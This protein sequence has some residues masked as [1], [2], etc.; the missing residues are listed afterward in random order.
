M[1]VQNQ[2]TAKWSP[3]LFCFSGRRGIHM[4]CHPSTGLHVLPATGRKTILEKLSRNWAKW[5]PHAAEIADHTIW[6]LDSS[7]IDFEAS[8]SVQGKNIRMPFSAHV[9]TEYACTPFDASRD[10]LPLQNYAIKWN[11][12]PTEW[13]E[14]TAKRATAAISLFETWIRDAVN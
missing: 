9:E 12:S 5:A 11:S 2:A 14:C 1:S 3:P 10:E 4:Y 13:E 8:Y 6:A 7:P